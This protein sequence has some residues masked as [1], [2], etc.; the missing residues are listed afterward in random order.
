MNSGA[1][2]KADRGWS[3]F[4]AIFLGVGVGLGLVLYGLLL[5]VDGYDTVFLSPRFDREPVTSNQRF[6]FPALARKDRFNVPGTAASSNWSRRMW[7]TVRGL[8][9]SRSVRKRMQL[10]RKLL[11]KTER[12]EPRINTD[13]H[14]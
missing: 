12:T 14:G 2:G 1:P 10:I 6:S 4:L 7:K 9:E 13:F 3:R 8:K 11:E 5:V